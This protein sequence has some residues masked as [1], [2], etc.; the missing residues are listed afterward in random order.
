MSMNERSHDRL[1]ELIALDALGG[2]DAGELEELRSLL[3]EHGE[4]CA[5]CSEMIAAY[6]DAA[7]VLAFALPPSGSSAGSEERLIA[8]ARARDAEAAPDELSARRAA[9][10]ER[11][12]AAHA[13]E[14]ADAVPAPPPEPAPAPAPVTS[15]RERRR[16]HPGRW[17]AAAAVAAAL[18]VGGV[19]G[20]VAAPRAP[21]GTRQFLAFSAQ[22]GTQFASFP[23]KDGSRLTVA[24]RHGQT[25]GWIFGTGL[26]KPAG[27]KTYELW[28]GSKDIPLSQFDPAGIF[29]PIHGNVISPV[30]VDIP[31]TGALLGVTIEPAGGS[32][33]PTS[34][35]ILV[36]PA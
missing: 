13:E 34:A 5:T 36:T 27:G 20:Y 17:I 19:S 33:R 32:S 2:L 25:D 3:A 14:P 16:S 29:V 10:E 28:V 31:R 23:T 8:A 12:A 11:E 4:D 22:P 35:P 1:E 18:L 21:E 15:V 26:D 6:A 24:F 30:H 9:R 7:A